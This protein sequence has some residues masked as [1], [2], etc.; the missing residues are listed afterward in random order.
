MGLRGLMARPLKRR[1]VTR[2]PRRVTRP[3][4][5]VTLPPRRVTRPPVEDW[6]PGGGPPPSWTQDDG[7]SQ[8]IGELI[9]QAFNQLSQ[10][11]ADTGTGLYEYPGNCRKYYS[12]DATGMLSL[13]LCD[14]DYFFRLVKM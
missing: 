3:P 7:L 9:R 14:E 1:R 12:C 6:T 11:C 8:G 2:P 13:E 4:R 10:D 5:P